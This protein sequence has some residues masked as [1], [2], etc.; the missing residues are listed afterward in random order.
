MLEQPQ[1][2]A[3]ATGLGAAG[4]KGQWGRMNVERSGRP[5]AGRLRLGTRSSPLALA[6]SRLV[7]QALAAAHGLAA[8]QVELVPVQTVGDRV[9]DRP[10]A[11]IGGKALWTKELDRA[12]LEGEID[13]AVHSMKDVETALHPGIRVAAVLPR[14]DVRDRLVGATDLAAL[15]HGATVGTSS[16]RRAAQLLNRRPDVHVVTIRGNVETRLRQVAE[17]RV[18]ATFLAAAGLARLG[19]EAGVA[20]PV[21]TWLPA[22]AQGI[23]G[24]T[25]RKGDARVLALLAAINDAPTM[26]CLVAERAVLEGLGGSCHTSVAVHADGRLLRAE[27]LSPDGGDRVDAQLPIGGDPHALGLALAEALMQRATPAIR[28]TLAGEGQ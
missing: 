8:D 16:P 7:A 25:C 12:L 19:I 18:G 1:S 17:G 10:L 11:E 14:A 4:G 27:L 13:L 22:A 2:G 28:A 24:V 20:L 3:D 6:Q 15:D 21:D 26:D 23:I 9:Q 5:H